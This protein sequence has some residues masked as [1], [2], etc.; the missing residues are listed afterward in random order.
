MHRMKNSITTDLQSKKAPLMTAQ[1]TDR[2]AEAFKYAAQ[3]HRSQLRKGTSIPYI[4]HL[5]S[6]SALIRENGGDEDQ[7]IAGLLHDVI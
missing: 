5:M 3:E 4:S 7:A 1:F 6:V 2:F